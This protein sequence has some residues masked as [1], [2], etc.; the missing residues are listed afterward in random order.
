MNKIVFKLSLLSIGLLATTACSQKTDKPINTIENKTAQKDSATIIAEKKQAQEKEK[1]GLPKP[2]N[3]IENAEEKISQL[4]KQAQTEN[5]NIIM[6]A[7]G[8]WCIWCL[9][10]NNYVQTTPEIKDVVDNNYIYYHLN[11]SPENKNEKV[12]AK[13]GNAGKKYGYPYFIVLD[14]NGNQLHIQESGFLEEGN[15]YSKEK[16]LEFFN[17]WKPKKG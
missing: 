7:G 5:K 16:V 9:R 3:P 2:Y 4:I 6:Q 12:F 1:A 10:F 13:Y 17:S 11:Y 8:N 14:K 15:G